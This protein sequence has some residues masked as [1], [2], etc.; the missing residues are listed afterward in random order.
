MQCNKPIQV[1]NQ[2]V[3]CGRCIS[4]RITRQTDWTIRMVHEFQMNN[5]IGCF[6][7]L[8]YNEDNLPVNGT[9]VK[10]DLQLFFKKV[11]KKYV[12]RYFAC[13]EYG[14]RGGRPHYHVIVFGVDFGASEVLRNYVERMWALGFVRIGTVSV[15]SCRYV[16]KYCTK[17]AVSDKFYEGREPEF[18]VMSRRPGIGSDWFDKYSPDEFI[19]VNGRKT[20][21]CRYYKEKYRPKGDFYTREDLDIFLDERVRFSRQKKKRQVMLSEKVLKEHDILVKSHEG[22]SHLQALLELMKQRERNLYARQNIKG[23]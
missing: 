12:F 17:G 9:L 14:S 6:L 15:S 23:A 20:G 21:L 19:Y 8:T 16:A 13:G 22:K 5:F 18:A 10:R 11:R 3:P 2:V 1:R 4:C 7:T